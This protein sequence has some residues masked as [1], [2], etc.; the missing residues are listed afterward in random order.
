[1]RC[2]CNKDPLQ[3]LALSLKRRMKQMLRLLMQLIVKEGCCFLGDLE[4]T[5]E[6]NDTSDNS[7]NATNSTEEEEEFINYIYQGENFKRPTGLLNK[8]AT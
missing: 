3:S 7:T 1:M 2:D 6:I 8:Q 5:E 4:E